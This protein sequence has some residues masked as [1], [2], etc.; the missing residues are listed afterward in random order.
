MVRTP[1]TITTAVPKG[2]SFPA[3]VNSH[4]WYDLPPFRSAEPYSELHAL[5]PLPT[6]RTVD[7]RLTA[8][9]VRLRIDIKQSGPLKKEEQ[10]AIRSTVRSMLRLDEPLE[11][12]YALCRRE[13]HLRWVPKRGAGRILRAPTVFEDVVKMLFTTNCSWSLTRIQTTHLTRKLGTETA[14]GLFTFPHPSAIARMSDA[15]LRREISCGYRAPYLLALCRSIDSGRIDLEPLRSSEAPTEELYRTLR[16]IKG[17]GHYAA[18]NILKLLGRYD[19]LG[20]DSWVR[21][22]FAEIHRNG[23]TVPDAAIERHY[24]RYGRW[25]G[26][27]CLMEVTAD[28]HA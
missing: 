16:S 6:R 20:I 15:W 11:E 13:P 24:D 26:L 5:I 25:R 17:I 22:R 2:F 7:V 18:G 14:P 1:V 4:G 28:W 12:F 8:G 23:R 3:T 21:S 9:T 10:D 27:V 19:H